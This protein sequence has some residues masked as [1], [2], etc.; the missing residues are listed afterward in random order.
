M[1]RPH[2]HNILHYINKWN[3]DPIWTTPNANF[4]NVFWNLDLDNNKNRRIMDIST[5][6]R[7]HIVDHVDIIAHFSNGIGQDTLDDMLLRSV[8]NCAHKRTPRQRK[9]K[10]KFNDS[11]IAYRI[12]FVTYNGL[13]KPNIL[14]IPFIYAY[15]EARSMNSTEHWHM[16]LYTVVHMRQSYVYSIITVNNKKLLDI[17]AVYGDTRNVIEYMRKQSPA[18]EFK[19][20]KTDV[21]GDWS[22]MLKTVI[23]L[24]PQNEDISNVPSQLAYHIGELPYYGNYDPKLESEVN[25]LNLGRWRFNSK[26]IVRFQN[27]H[28]IIIYLN[29]LESLILTKLDVFEIRAGNSFSFPNYKNE[30]VV[31]LDKSD[32]NLVRDIGSDF[33]L[34]NRRNNIFLL[35]VIGDHIFDGFQEQVFT[36][37]FKLFQ[38]FRTGTFRE[39]TTTL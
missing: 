19:L 15:I 32:D 21:Y 10:G 29:C 14:E 36:E 8:Y 25:T 23:P 11:D 13:D 12:F 9:D 31:V 34:H 1:V 28:D 5:Y 22:N 3:T 2:G 26:F 38:K 35:L 27:R 37:R 16:M 20:F 18:S 17:Q 6:M 7:T 24:S 33:T 39:D 30:V 4:F